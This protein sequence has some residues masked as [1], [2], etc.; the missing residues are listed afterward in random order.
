MKKCLDTSIPS[1]DESAV[2]CCGATPSNCVIA[3]E[4][5]S[6]LKFLKG[7]TLTSILKVISDK[8]KSI[9]KNFAYKEYVAVI[10]QENT[11]APTSFVVNNTYSGVTF[12]W[13]YTSAGEYLLTAS[14]AI[15]PLDET[16]LT[17]PSPSP[18]SFNIEIIVS[19][20]TQII[21]RTYDSSGVLADD[22]LSR[23]PLMIRTKL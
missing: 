1:V 11:D 10:T 2:E 21:I 9:S 6:Y 23:A 20:T 3:S 8:F 19:T 4:A 18:Q 12:T 14:S 15:F 7:A 17:C 5:D 13:S 16:Y 22:L